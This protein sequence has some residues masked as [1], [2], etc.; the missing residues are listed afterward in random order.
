MIEISGR[1]CLLCL[2]TCTWVCTD[3][4]RGNWDTFHPGHCKS[5]PVNDQLLW[6]LTPDL[7]PWK[8]NRVWKGK[9]V[10]LRK[11]SLPKQR[12]KLSHPSAESSI[13]FLI[14]KSRREAQEK[15]FKRCRHLPRT[16]P[17]ALPSCWLPR[18]WGKL[19]LTH[20]S[21]AMWLWLSQPWSSSCHKRGLL[22]G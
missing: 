17:P 4:I 12:I 11:G 7:L 6:V 13:G 2:C 9:E 21:P 16:H 22:Q 14:I 10:H 15:L 8:P 18:G 1:G 3:D 19:A 20:P 5:W